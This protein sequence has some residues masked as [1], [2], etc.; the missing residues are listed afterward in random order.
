MFGG[1]LIALL[2]ALAVVF[3]TGAV[4]APGVLEARALSGVRVLAA[5]LAV[6]L[7]MWVQTALRARHPPAEATTLLVAL[8][9]L[10]P[11]VA[12]VLTVLAGVTL[13]AVLGEAA[14]RLFEGDEE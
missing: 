4:D 3:V 9:A 12:T 6:L 11:D 13:V 14:R 10:K 5:V 7:S 2:C 8:G 1:H